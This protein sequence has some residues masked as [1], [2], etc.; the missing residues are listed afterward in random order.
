MSQDVKKYPL[1]D[2][3]PDAVLNKK[4]LAT[5]LNVT[6]PTIDRY[7]GRGMPVAEEGGNGRSYQFQL[8][9][10]YAWYC[11]QRDEQERQTAEADRAAQQMRLALL[12]GEAG[13]SE[14]ALPAKERAQIY[15][16]EQRYLAAA[17]ERGRLIPV[18]KVVDLLESVFMTIRDAVDALPDRLE[19]EAGLNG[20]QVDAAVVACD[21]MLMETRRHIETANLAPT[22]GSVLGDRESDRDLH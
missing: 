11:G 3:V 18:E 7:I 12:G 15:E 20:K 16:A 21:D 14:R 10:C 22:A 1:P 19:R 6:E 2:G 5:A 17:R 4:Q 9:D 13:D 8:S